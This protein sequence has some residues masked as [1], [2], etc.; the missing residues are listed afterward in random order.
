MTKKI[1]LN[2]ISAINHTLD[3]AMDKDKNIVVWG[4]DVG[5]EGGVFRATKGLQ[6]KYGEARVFDSP[7]DEA[8]ILGV[9]VGAAI[10]GLKPV[11]EIQFLGFVYSAFQNLFGHAARFRN[12]TRGRFTC[13]LV[14]RIPMGGGIRGIEHHSESIE[15]IFSHI[16]GLKV[17]MPYTPYD[18]KGLLLAAINDPDP[19]IFLEPKR[20]YRS[21]R[22]EIPEEYYEIEIG[23]GN[24]LKEGK[25]ITIVSYG[26]ILQDV[27]KAANKLEE[28]HNINVEVID[29]RTITPWDRELVIAS[30]KKTQNLL[31][32]HEEVESFSTSSEI[33]AVVSKECFYHLERPVQRLAPPDITVP[34]PKGEDLYQ[35][36]AK[37]IIITVLDM[38][39][40][41]D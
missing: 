39:K 25:D 3:L 28:K 27:L 8:T 23:K 5:L 30:V 15:A 20:V 35:I 19:V 11:V 4:E 32:V 26:A 36:N 14:V 17:V 18:T 16:P 13:P 40:G 9:A 38:L 37:K 7:L 31:I 21:F 2:N 29:L 22:Q 10:N 12:R 34:L 33:N 6:K 1:P 41:G 24:I